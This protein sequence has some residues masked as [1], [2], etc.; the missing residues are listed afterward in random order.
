MNEISS[1]R[2]EQ[3]F[4]KT[5]KAA[6]LYDYPNPDRVG[7][8]KDIQV[9]KDLAAKKLDVPDSIVQHVVECSPCFREMTELRRK[10]KRLRL[11]K[12]CTGVAGLLLIVT[13]AAFRY[14]HSGSRAESTAYLTAA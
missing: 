4:I 14:R 6:A 10:L 1:R 7:C 12:I 11:V 2:E 8:P 13:L 3:R 5:L 9:L